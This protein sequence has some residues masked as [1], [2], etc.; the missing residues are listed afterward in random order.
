VNTVA[1]IQARLDSSRLPGKVLRP[2]LSRPLLWHVVQRVRAAAGV[3]DVLV[4]TSQEASEEPIRA[5]CSQEKIPCFAGDKHDVLARYYHAARSCGAEAVVRVT[6]DSAMVD[7]LIVNRIIQCFAAGDYDH[8]SVAA[9]AGTEDLHQGR[10][11]DGL[12][13]ECIR[14][15]ALERAFHEATALFQREHVTPYLWQN[16]RV[17][18]LGQLLADDDYSQLRL[19]V[20][21]PAD[22]ELIEHIYAELYAPSRSFGL[23]DI[24]SL[25][26]RR[27]EL[28]AHNRELIGAKEYLAVDPRA[29]EKE[30]TST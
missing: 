19:T 21:Y 27:P 16:P 22:F 9:G 25:F 18:R 10:F 23:A 4:A 13:V 26:E 15:D 3:D 29:T 28:A 8:F 14:F 12:D 5:F 7:P 20:D 11:P 6:G 30:L 1:I 24:V 2:I 17:F